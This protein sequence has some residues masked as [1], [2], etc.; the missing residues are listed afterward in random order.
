METAT[1]LILHRSETNHSDHYNLDI[2][3]VLCRFFY[4]TEMLCSICGTHV[5]HLKD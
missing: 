4:L 5:E 3:E 1:H 2:H